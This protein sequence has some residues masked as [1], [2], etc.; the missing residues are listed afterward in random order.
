MLA[1]VVICDLT[2]WWVI[3][4]QL[5]SITAIVVVIAILEIISIVINLWWVPVFKSKTKIVG[6]GSDWD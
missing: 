2:T 5:K 4:K 6:G 3:M 1:I